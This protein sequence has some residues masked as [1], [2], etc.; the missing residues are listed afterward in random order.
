MFFLETGTLKNIDYFLSAK[1]NAPKA[2]FIPY[3]PT[4]SREQGN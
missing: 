1:K 4:Y 2:R 3:Q